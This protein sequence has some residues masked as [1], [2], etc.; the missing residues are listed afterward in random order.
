[1]RRRG[2]LPEHKIFLLVKT[3][4]KIF[5]SQVVRDGNHVLRVL[6]DAVELDVSVVIIY[7][8]N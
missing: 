2:A 6:K 4:L 8:A 5:S 3:Q 7:Q 1:M